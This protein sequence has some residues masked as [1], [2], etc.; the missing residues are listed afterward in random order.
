[1]PNHQKAVDDFRQAMFVDRDPAALARL[2]SDDA[3][4]LDPGAD[5]PIRG[6]QAIAAYHAAYLRAFPDLG[7][8]TRNVFG[9]GDWFAA[10]LH[11]SGTHTGPLEVEPG[12]TLA[13]TGRKVDLDVCWVGRLAADGRLVEDH[14]YYDSAAFA[15]LVG[16]AAGEGDGT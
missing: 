12:H 15:A 8:E 9:S 14:T 6:N 16:A 13:P 2:Y 11:V 3:V 7:A 4:L 10:E 1:M 5:G